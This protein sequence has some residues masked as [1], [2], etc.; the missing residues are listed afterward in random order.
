[1][2]SKKVNYLLILSV[3]IFGISCQNRMPIA[4]MKKYMAK[5]MDLRI[6]TENKK[7]SLSKKEFPKVKVSLNNFTKDTIKI[8][9]P[10]DGSNVGWR[11][12]TIR[13]SVIDLEKEE[14]HPDTLPEIKEKISRCGNMNGLNRRDI[15]SLRPKFGIKLKWTSDP[16][17]PRRLGKYSVRFY[18]EHK[19]DSDWVMNGYPENEGKRIINEET[20][21][22]FLVSNE[23]VFEIIE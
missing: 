14:S 22:M 23:L 6:T 2:K 16:S 15:V 3:L 7:L 13:W 21:E 18:F 17:I 11:T 8:L 10:G 4:S 19:P 5:E 12:P 20:E 1:M 9:Q